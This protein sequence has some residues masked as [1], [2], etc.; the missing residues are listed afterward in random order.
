MTEVSKVECPVCGKLVSLTKERR[1]R[2]HLNHSGP[3]VDSIFYPRCEGS[4]ERAPRVDLLA[5]L[6][7]SFDRAKESPAMTAGGTLTITDF[8]WERIAED[9]AAAGSYHRLL[10]MRT[11]CDNEGC[12]WDDQERMEDERVCTCG[13]PAH[14]LAECKAKREIVEECERSILNDKDSSTAEWIAA[15]LA[16]V[17][18][19]HPDYDPAWAPES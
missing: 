9:E 11:A 2:H 10:C 16:T 12:V 3:R 13:Y 15:H 14:V 7:A 8:L 6:Q 19:S 4:G 5:A 1:L 18:A 17:Y